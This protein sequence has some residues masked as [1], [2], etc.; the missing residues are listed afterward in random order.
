M[1]NVAFRDTDNPTRTFVICS[2]SSPE[3]GNTPKD[4]KPPLRPCQS[5]IQPL[6]VRQKPDVTTFIVPYSGEDDDIFFAAFEAIDSL[7]FN[8]L[9]LHSALDAKNSFES[10]LIL[11]VRVEKTQKKRDL[12]R[13]RCDDSDIVALETLQALKNYDDLRERSI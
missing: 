5:H 10:F 1:F 13:V 9:H 7:D 6:L 12:R 3:R 4:K 2:L 11:R 8:M